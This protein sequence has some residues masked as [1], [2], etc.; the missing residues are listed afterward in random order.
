MKSVV[1]LLLLSLLVAVPASAIQ[2]YVDST[3]GNDTNPGTSPSLPWKTLGKAAA[4]LAFGDTVDIIAGSYDERITPANSGT[5]GNAITYQASVTCVPGSGTCPKLRGITLT[6]KSYIIVKGLEFTNAG[7]SSDTN[8]TIII[9]GT[10]GVQ[11]LN[12]YIHDTTTITAGI[13]SS[14]SGAKASGLVVNGNTMANIGTAGVRKAAMQL[15]ADDTLIDSND[16]S[17]AG[18]FVDLFGTR[19]VIRN[20]TFHDSSESD[21]GGE[22]IDAL[23]SF[24]AG[25]PSQAAS[26]VL[27]EGNVHKNNP[28]LNSHFGLFNGTNSCAGLNP[29]T[30]IIARYNT[31]S[32]IGSG[33]WGAIDTTDHHKIYNNTLVSGG[34]GVSPKTVHTT[35]DVSACT[36]CSVLNNIFVD[37]IATSAPAQMYLLKSADVTSAGDYNLAF[38]TTA[39]ITWANPINAEVHHILNQTP[40]FV[41]GTD[42]HLQAASPARQAGS[43]LTTVALG[44]SGSGT[45][46]VLADAHFFQPGWAGVSADWIAVGNIRNSVQISSINY[47]TNT[48]TLAGPIA[49]S[50][51]QPV[52]LYKNSSGAI[53]LFA[54]RSSAAPDLG[55][56]AYPTPNPATGM[57]VDKIQ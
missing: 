18:D 22:H 8:A 39:T 51:G 6:N 23:Q 30:T 35:A 32:N 13:L 38:M 46:L 53:V 42:F 55:A 52:W 11:I 34:V 7:F 2:Y 20:N 14:S 25:T 12:N 29:T 26:Y 9:G 16:I 48:I 28:D 56:L 31:I 47:A 33:L 44:D 3:S 45:A 1:L 21:A 24:C 19:A 15:W 40:T 50:P 54:Q 17:H 36:S 37:A 5:P 41:S 4:T 10:T 49:R 27:L 43:P 57:K